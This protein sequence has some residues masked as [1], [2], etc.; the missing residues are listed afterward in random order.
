MLDRFQG[1][2]TRKERD[3][4]IKIFMTS[5]SIK[6]LVSFLLLVGCM[7]MMCDSMLMSLKCGGVGLN[8]VRA[9][10]VINLDLAVRLSFPSFCV[11]LTQALCQWSHSVEAQAFDRAHVSSAHSPSIS[12]G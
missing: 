7:L 2:M 4:S 10:R 9:N 3:K 12:R 5:R 6:V 11:V 8:L 1:D